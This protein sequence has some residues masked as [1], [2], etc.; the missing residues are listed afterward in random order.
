[1]VDYIYLGIYKLFNLFIVIVP[2]GVI[3]KFSSGLAW[4]AYSVSAKRRKIIQKNLDIVYGD[5]LSEEKRKQIAIAAFKNL[6]DTVLGLMVRNSM[7]QKQILDTVVFENEEVVREYQKRGAKLIFISGHYGNWE[8]MAPAIAQKFNI[9]FTVVGRKMNS[10]VMNRVLKK[11]RE[12]FNVELVYKKGAMKGCIKALNQKKSVGILVDQ[13]IKKNQSVD[14]RF[15]GHTVTHTPMASILSRKY[16][17]DLIPVFIRSESY[18]KYRIKIYDPI[19][20]IKTDNVDED[21]K[22]MTQAQADIMEKVI[23]EDPT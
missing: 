3:E 23:R 22:Q 18:G 1:M 12:R 16:E 9:T 4:F 2:A 6:I 19:K 15:F 21:I 8:L 17:T 7:D 5:E 14:V 10:D 13:S 20:Y 11:S